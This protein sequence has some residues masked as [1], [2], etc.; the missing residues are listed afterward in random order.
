MAINAKL[1]DTKPTIDEFKKLTECLDGVK[2][3]FK[4]LDEAIPKSFAD[5]ISSYSKSVVTLTNTLDKM[6]Q[7]FKNI[8]NYA[9]KAVT[10]LTDLTEIQG[11]HSR[12]N[13][14]LTQLERSLQGVNTDHIER[15]STSLRRLG[16]SLANL[17]RHGHN[18][19]VTLKDLAGGFNVTSRF[20]DTISS[21]THEP[22]AK[23]VESL[24]ASF[25]K[26]FGDFDISNSGITKASSVLASFSKSITMFNKDAEQV[27]D[28]LHNKKLM[29]DLK[30][31]ITSFIEEFKHVSVE[32]S[33]MKE[34]EFYKSDNNSL[35]MVTKSLNIDDILT[36]MKRVASSGK[37]L[38][39]YVNSPEFVDFAYKIGPEVREAFNSFG[40]ELNKISLVLTS[41]TSSGTASNGAQYT[42][43]TLAVDGVLDFMTQ[44]KSKI[45]KMGELAQ[46]PEFTS[47]RE[48][49]TPL[50]ESLSEFT[51]IINNLTVESNTT[52]SVKGGTKNIPAIDKIISIMNKLNDAVVKITSQA[53]AIQGAFKKRVLKGLVGDIKKFINDLNSIKIELNSVTE[54]KDGST[55][56]VAN[57]DRVIQYINAVANLSNK[58]GKAAPTGTTGLTAFVGSMQIAISQ[59]NKLT[60][61]QSFAGFERLA[62]AMYKLSMGAKSVVTGVD[63]AERALRKYSETTSHAAKATN[64][65]VGG[66]RAVVN[67]FTGGTVIY[68]IVRTIREAVDAFVEFDKKLRMINTL[69]GMSEKALSSLG[70]EIVAT[71]GKFGLNLT[72]AADSMFAIQSAT[73]RGADALRVFNA[74]A[75]L[76]VAGGADLRNS[77]ELITRSLMAYGKHTTEPQ[78]IADVL[79]KT[80]D[81]G[82][83]TIEELAHNLTKVIPSAVAA[84]V[85]FEEINAAMA[86]LTTKGLQTTVASTALNSMLLKLT[87]GS[88]KLDAV[89]QKLGYDSSATA[90]KQRG[91]EF[92]MRQISAAT[93][94][95]AYELQKLGFNY[96]DIKAAAILAN[97]TSGFFA[98]TLRYI[99]DEAEEGGKA[100]QAYKEVSKSLGQQIAQI[101]DTLKG[102]V[103]GI[104][105][106]VAKWSGLKVVLGLIN[107]FVQVKSDFSTLIGAFKSIAGPIFK[108]VSGITIMVTSL[109]LAVGAVVR[110]KAAIA[111]LSIVALT[112]NV[113]KLSKTSNIYAIG[114]A[115]LF[116]TVGAGSSAV[117]RYIGALLM[118]RK[119]KK[120]VRDATISQA[121]AEVRLAREMRRVQAALVVLKASFMAFMKATA[122][123]AIVAAAIYGISAA[124]DFFAKKRADKRVRA[125]SSEFS[126]L[127]EEIDNLKTVT[128]VETR[129]ES[130]SS[131]LEELASMSQTASVKALTK[132]Y[133]EA[134]EKLNQK[135]MDLTSDGASGD[136]FNKLTEARKKLL[137]QDTNKFQQMS[138][139]QN[140]NKELVKQLALLP[141]ASSAWAKMATKITD[142]TAKIKKMA[143]ELRD[144][145]SFIPEHLSNK[146]NKDFGDSIKGTKEQ[147]SLKD[148]QLF[149]ELR[150][151][152]LSTSDANSFLSQ[153]SL[154]MSDYLRASGSMQGAQSVREKLLT[155]IHRAMGSGLVKNSAK[156]FTNQTITDMNKLGIA[157]VN[158]YDKAHLEKNLP[159]IMQTIAKLNKEI[160][161]ASVSK[162]SGEDR[163][164]EML[165]LQQKRLFAIVQIQERLVTGNKNATAFQKKSLE[166]AKR[167][168]AAY[169]KNL[170]EFGEYRRM[171][172]ISSDSLSSTDWMSTL[173]VGVASGKNK[174]NRDAIE[175][176]YRSVSSFR[177]ILQEEAKKNNF[178]TIAVAKVMQSNKGIEN[179]TKAFAKVVKTSLK[180]WYST[181]KPSNIL[182]GMSNNIPALR[183]TKDQADSVGK[184]R[185]AIPITDRIMKLLNEWHKKQFELNYKLAEAY[186]NTYGSTYQ[187]QAAGQNIGIQ[188]LVGSIDRDYYKD[189]ADALISPTGVTHYAV[190]DAGN[191]LKNAGVLSSKGID[192]NASNF[193]DAATRALVQAE[194]TGGEKGKQATQK[195][196][197]AFLAYQQIIDT[198]DKP[199][200]M[201][202]E[203]LGT[204]ADKLKLLQK[205]ATLLEKAYKE[206][207]K[208]N[209]TPKAMALSDAIMS[210]KISQQQLLQSMTPGKA[211]PISEQVGWSSKDAYSLMY[212]QAT[213]NENSRRFYQNVGDIN[214]NVKQC[215]KLLE[216]QTKEVA[217]RGQ[218]LVLNVINGN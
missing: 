16:E 155:R 79:F 139:L 172:D 98:E 210:N 78:H 3:A 146:V 88:E 174:M 192:F 37:Q 218:K 143:D 200:R 32:L 61:T 121:V 169:S 117:T 108:V 14:A 68:T 152:G 184:Y 113:A 44:L 101:V 178:D 217:Q 195:L 180:K 29:S 25:D 18:G 53:A 97:D 15:V 141:Q 2:N 168:L 57:I 11:G 135:K 74:S 7:G 173:T 183:T 80:Q 77:T 13:T 59:L 116:S 76:S 70:S 132:E 199:S 196:V 115:Q 9:D 43:K 161:D 211:V 177:Q 206:A 89:F 126:K 150:N 47:F 41:T 127:T 63:K 209:D 191:V 158:G 84:R 82:I 160:A 136:A 54:G 4:G 23:Y 51:R 181:I 148:Q 94:G 71:S 205:D 105:E 26:S 170:K 179:Y 100:L 153:T 111:S 154:R 194:A 40:S 124:W 144:L 30:E 20:E 58:I 149:M 110:L 185:A 159:E 48:M 12:F 188:H 207:V 142:N 162:M 95:T 17:S 120:A 204:T 176:L 157:G 137:M 36:L 163:V 214:G 83:T 42:T 45:N 99:N 215:Q 5:T 6:G 85:S 151:A 171:L 156:S 166:E 69:A 75:M 22:V 140:E 193:R 90:L 167:Q 19:V 27:V 202:T 133:Q 73:L 65:F 91:L 131:K 123:L 86:T 50:G 145:Y 104:S 103:V 72:Q 186:R 114:L 187:M 92:V 208:K 197:N 24:S 28:K 107:S 125:I 102:A 87:S 38:H 216:R 60:L 35:T 49:I 164:N 128:Q 67:A 31:G 134:I 147:L 10:T 1:V 66:W 109:T 190:I 33:S 138:M 46:S 129:I 39:S 62:D 198:W 122:V 64:W 175:G 182:A 112:G 8:S 56:N 118:L 212:S 119:T 52:V 21:E 106:F 81:R 93:G 34:V 96:R 55:K 130:L 189:L 201:Y 165:A 203:A 213:G